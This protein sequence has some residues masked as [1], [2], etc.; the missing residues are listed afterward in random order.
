MACLDAAHALQDDSLVE[1]HHQG[2]DGVDRESA[3]VDA[4]GPHGA[5][6][7]VGQHGP[8]L[9]VDPGH[10]LAEVGVVPRHGLQLEPDL[11]IAGGDVLLEEPHGRAPLLEEGDVG[12]V[13]RPLPLDQ[14]VGEPLQHA[15]EQVL[16]GAEVVVDEAVVDA[17]LLGHQPGGDGGVPDAHQ[18]TLGRIEQRLLRLHT[19]PGGCHLGPPPPVLVV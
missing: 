3:A 5:L 9:G 4:V 6:E 13:H 8:P 12:R 1:R 10:P 17:R 18:Q 14:L 7:G 15:Q 19:R 11:G 2:D 16:H